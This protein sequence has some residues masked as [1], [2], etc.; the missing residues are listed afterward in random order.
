MP[1]WLPENSMLLT[2]SRICCEEKADLHASIH[3]GCDLVVELSVDKQQCRPL[4]LVFGQII[5]GSGALGSRFQ[6]SLQGTIP[7]HDNLE[8]FGIGQEVFVYSMEA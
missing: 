1:V 6:L 5:V 3:E 4:P 8:A 2:E 7:R